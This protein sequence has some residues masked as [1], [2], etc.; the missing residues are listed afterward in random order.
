MTV[1]CSLVQ[2]TRG[3]VL[4]S[5][6]VI[7]ILVELHQDFYNILYRT[8]QAH[9][10]RALY[11]PWPIPSDGDSTTLALNAGNPEVQRLMAVI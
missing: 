6:S 1:A 5:L 10:Y 3:Q 7:G 9:A 11:R 8:F 2:I 4:F